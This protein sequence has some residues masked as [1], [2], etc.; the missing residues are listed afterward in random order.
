MDATTSKF[1]S[2]A[3]LAVVAA[4]LAAAAI[5][6]TV[7][8]AAGGGSSSSSDGATSGGDLAVYIQAQ[9]DAPP[10]SG[11]G[12]P[13]EA[14]RRRLRPGRRLGR[15]LRL[16]RHQHGR[17]LARRS[18]GRARF[19]GFLPP[20]RHR[21]LRRRQDSSARRMAAAKRRTGTEL[22]CYG[23]SD[24]ERVV[25]SCSSDAVRADL[26]LVACDRPVLGEGSPK[27]P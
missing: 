2:R 17:P 12:C 11:D 27:T 21:S 13:E 23:F 9:E 15:R 20:F 26:G 25:R 22:R 14:V 5:W 3:L 6:A 7:G 10:A 1:G 8:L 16:E 4:L 24:A 18:P 19:G